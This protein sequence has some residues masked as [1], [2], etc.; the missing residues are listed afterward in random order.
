[1]STISIGNRELK[2]IS[3]WTGEILKDKIGLNHAQFSLVFDNKSEIGRIL[4]YDRR[5][6]RSVIVCE[7]PVRT[8]ANGEDGYE[9]TLRIVTP[10]PTAYIHAEHVVRGTIWYEMSLPKGEL[11]SG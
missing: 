1:M 11:E 2:V 5:N 7:E 3:F 8:V 6:G 9:H 4:T 10:D